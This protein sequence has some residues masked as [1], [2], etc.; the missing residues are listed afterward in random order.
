MTA[1][2]EDKRFQSNREVMDRHGIISLSYN[3]PVSDYW[4][5]FSANFAAGLRTLITLSSR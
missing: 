5:I 4:S 3:R 1:V 2:L